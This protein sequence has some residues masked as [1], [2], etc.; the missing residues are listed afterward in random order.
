MTRDTADCLA[1]VEFEVKEVAYRA[2]WSQSRA[3]NQPD[4]NLQ[5]LVSS[6][7]AVRTA[8]SSPTK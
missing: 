8:R 5:V 7:P 3:R 6:W 1:E 2:F 4:G